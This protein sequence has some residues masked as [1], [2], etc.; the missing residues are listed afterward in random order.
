MR[1][2]MDNLTT[3]NYPFDASEVA[4]EYQEATNTGTG[5]STNYGN[6]APDY[7]TN[8]FLAPVGSRDKQYNT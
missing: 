8:L 6:P 3:Y 2:Q 4:Y 1:A 7:G 5:G